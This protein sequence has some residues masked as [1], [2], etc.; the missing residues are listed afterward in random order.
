MLHPSLPVRAFL[1]NPALK[2]VK[3]YNTYFSRLPLGRMTIAEF[4]RSDLL[5]ARLFLHLRPDPAFWLACGQQIMDEV[6]ASEADA[7]RGP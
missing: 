3:L 7:I 2:L 6:E 4:L 5:L 1:V